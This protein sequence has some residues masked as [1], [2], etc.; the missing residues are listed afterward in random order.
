MSCGIIGLTKPLRMVVF[1]VA[2]YMTNF[3]KHIFFRPRLSREAWLAYFHRLPDTI[4]V[5]WQRDGGFIIGRVRAGE[6]RFCTQGRNAR[7]FIEMVND[8]IYA[9]FDIP[10]AYSGTLKSY[11]PNHEDMQKLADGSIPAHAFNLKKQ[12]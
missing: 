4:E 12:T 6:H 1:P 9:V 11:A 8:A 2:T 10:E 3:I 7:E 5:D